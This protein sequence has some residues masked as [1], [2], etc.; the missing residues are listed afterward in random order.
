MHI[1]SKL[2]PLIGIALALSPFARADRAYTRASALYIVPESE[3]AEE[4]VGG[5]VSFGASFSSIN[6]A[7]ANQLELE[8][9]WAQWNDDIADIGSRDDNVTFV[10]LLVTL[11]HEFALTDN[12]RLAIGPSGGVSYVKVSGFLTDP[13]SASDWIFTYG[14]GATLSL[15]ISE[16]VS[17]SAGYRYLVN[18]DASIIVAGS[19][20][21]VDDLNMHVFE[22]GLTFGWPEWTP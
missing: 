18:S 19:E 21:K 12:L 22:L 11:R 15:A 3:S 16:S 7:G 8:A 9:G 10:P 14:A 4:T 17:L 20:V 1:C 5:I 6:S 13:G 2:I